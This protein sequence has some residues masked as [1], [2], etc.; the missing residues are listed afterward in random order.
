MGSQHG[1][2]KGQDSRVDAALGR[3]AGAASDAVHRARE[4]AAEA[5]AGVAGAA[6]VAGAVA[7]EAWLGAAGAAVEAVDVLAETV[8]A[9]G[10]SAPPV[11]S[12]AGT[13]GATP[14]PA[15]GIVEKLSELSALRD[16]GA[17]DDEEFKAAKAQ[18]LSA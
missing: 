13:G 7:A 6:E 14:T 9:G 10:L 2:G 1:A 15:S 8:G 3:L 4:L 16:T 12:K 17:L 5:V 18:L 11:G